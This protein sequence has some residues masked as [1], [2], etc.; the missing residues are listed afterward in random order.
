MPKPNSAYK[1]GK[2]SRLKPLLAQQSNGRSNF[3]LL[4]GAPSKIEP[5]N[6]FILRFNKLEE[7]LIA[8][9]ERI[10][11]NRY[12]QNKVKMESGTK[13]DVFA[14]TLQHQ[15]AAKRFTKGN[16]L[17]TRKT[18]QR[19]AHPY[20]ASIVRCNALHVPRLFLRPAS[21]MLYFYK[22]LDDSLPAP[23]DS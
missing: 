21:T 14:Q 11:P 5:K 23:R 3:N 7:A 2:V 8:A 17:Q 19:R 10:A 9:A 20:S 18:S 15:K 16:T 6:R 12:A 4:F 13:T 22:T 1:G